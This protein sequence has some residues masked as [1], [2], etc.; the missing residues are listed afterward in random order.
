VTLKVA[1]LTGTEDRE[2]KVFFNHYL[3]GRVTVVNT[4][5]VYQS[6]K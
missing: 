2:C 1:P 4:V 3:D 5:N 6:N